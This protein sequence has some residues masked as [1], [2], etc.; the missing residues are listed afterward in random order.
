LRFFGLLVEA[1][2]NFSIGVKGSNPFNKVGRH[3]ALA[4]DIQQH[5]GLDLVES[6]FNI[7]CEYCW[8]GGVLVGGLLFTDRVG[9]RRYRS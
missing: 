8:S 2:R 7:E 1:K 3:L 6:T 5:Q 9:D 4:H